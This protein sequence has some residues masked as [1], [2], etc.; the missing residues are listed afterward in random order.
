MFILQIIWEKI[1]L[2]VA[3]ALKNN[4]IMLFFL[5][6]WAS[7]NYRDVFITTDYVYG[8]S[9]NKYVVSKDLS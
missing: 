5:I 6:M 1:A 2:W 8:L 9:S 4:K 7:Y 3:N